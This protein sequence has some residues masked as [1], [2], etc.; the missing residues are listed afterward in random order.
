MPR[1]TRAERHARAARWVDSL[2]GDRGADLAEL[3]AHHYLAALELFEAAG[4]DPSD[5]VSATVDALLAAAQ[6]SHRLFAFTQAV[7]YAS[8]ALDLAGD[9]D[10]RRS[11]LLFALASA[12][13]DLAQVDAFSE[14]AAQAA[15]GYVTAGDLESA[16]RVEN[17]TA[18]RAVE[19]RA[20][21]RGQRGGGAS[22]GAGSR[23]AGVADHCGGPRR[24]FATPDARGPLRRGDRPGDV[25]AGR[26]AAV[27][28][29]A[30]RG[31]PAHHPRNGSG[32]KSVRVTSASSR[33]VP[34]SPTGSTSHSSTPVDTTTSLSCSSRTVTSPAPRHR[35]G[36]R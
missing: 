28:R 17:L 23:P 15:A 9:G 18:R 10:H 29:R 1:A 19:L 14:T 34:T 5:L 12:Q 27:R 25:G 32:T 16:A 2:A 13:G 21:G 31:K 4:R 35:W 6:Q 22:A 7:H 36:W 33:T 20:P 26:G 30:Q 24:T 3:R 8:R 11:E